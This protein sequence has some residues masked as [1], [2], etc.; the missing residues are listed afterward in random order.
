M[1]EMHPRPRGEPEESQELVQSISAAGGALAGTALTLV[2]GP[3]VGSASGELVGR[4][5]LRVGAEVQRRFFAPRQER[6]IGRAFQVAAER[7]QHRLEGGEAPRSDDFWLR[8]DTGRSDAEELLEG[9]LLNA[10]NAFEER[11]VELLARLY[12]SLEFRSDVSPGHANYL[13]NLT[14]RLTYRQLVLLG[15]FSSPDTGRLS[16]IDAGREE[17]VRRTTDE[18]LAE[19]NEMSSVGVLGVEQD[20]GF[21]APVQATMGG[22]TFRGI[23]LMRIEPTPL[24][25]TLA[26][27]LELDDALSDD[28]RATIYTELG[29]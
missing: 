2:A 7:T 5:L 19:M 10:A 24:G 29:E 20:G 12:A 21:V 17:G 26:E 1:D 15:V 16:L 8:D 14:D 4:A 11:K 25:T 23:S 3:F 6:R 22:G 27:L 18:I 13:L 9:V 28:D